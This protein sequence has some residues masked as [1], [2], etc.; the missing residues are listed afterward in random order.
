MRPLNLLSRL[1]VDA[2]LPFS[3]NFNQTRSR[4]VRKSAARRASSAVVAAPPRGRGR[5]R[6]IGAK[7]PAAARLGRAAPARVHG[8]ASPVTWPETSLAGPAAI[9][10]R[11]RDRAPAPETAAAGD[12]AASKRTAEPK[13]EV[14]ELCG[15]CATSA[16]A[17]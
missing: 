7:V 3:L 16:R 12:E 1:L 15:L 8:S 2:K 9:V 4:G 5:R 11:L 17:P 6:G 14:G 13:P 10:R